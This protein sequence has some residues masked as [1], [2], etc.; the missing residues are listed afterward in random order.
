MDDVMA[1]QERVAL[2]RSLLDLYNR[3]QSDPAWLEKGM[4]ALAADAEG[5]DVPSGAILRGPDGHKRLSL[6]FA[7]SFPDS[8]I[9]LTNAFA[10]EDQVVL[11]GT[12]RWTDTVPLPLPPG[13]L[14]RMS[15]SGQ[16][17]RCFI[18]PLTTLKFPTLPN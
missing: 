15:R 9:E 3:R 1:A 10:T 2:A 17:G 5:I 7:E 8:R 11:E 6:F 12:W 13:A 14:P 16:L 4:A 18:F